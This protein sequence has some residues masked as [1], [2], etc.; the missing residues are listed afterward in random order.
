MPRGVNYIRVP[1]A[2]SKGDIAKFAAVKGLV[3][4][5]RVVIGGIGF[6]SR[7]LRFET[8]AGARQSD[9][10]YHGEYLFVVV[11]PLVTATACDFLASIPGLAGPVEQDAPDTGEPDID[12]NADQES[13]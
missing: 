11:A 9:G 12:P 13:E 3:N 1:A 6:Q 8:F 10:L 7:S 2:I 5:E 4:Q